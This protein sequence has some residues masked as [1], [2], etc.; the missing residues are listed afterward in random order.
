MHHEA[1]LPPA[2]LS[3]AIWP[4]TARRAGYPLKA[5][6]SFCMAEGVE[7]FSTIRP[8]PGASNRQRGK[9]LPLFIAIADRYRLP[10]QGD[11]KVTPK[12]SRKAM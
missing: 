7:T 8:S 4:D 2:F 6:G 10:N 1:Q 5:A 11:G 9:S 12:I 3:G